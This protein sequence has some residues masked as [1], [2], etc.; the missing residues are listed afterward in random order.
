MATRRPPLTL[1]FEPRFCANHVAD[2]TAGCTFGCLYCPFADVGA[3]AAGV[4]APLGVDMTALERVP[5]PATVML[6][7]ASDPFAP[8]A[9]ARTHA[10]LAH[11]LPRGTVVA[12]LTKGTIPERTLDLLAAHAPQIEGVGVGLTSLDDARNRRLEP[13][14]PS[15]PARLDT[16]ARVA[17][18]GLAC[19]LRL[20]PIFPDL[21]DDDAAL[22]AL[23]DAA[24]DRGATGVTAT[25]LFAFG[26]SLRRLRREPL[27]AAS[28][29]CLT[30]RA[31]MEGGV[32]FSVPLGRKLATYAR[33]AGLCAARRIRF[34]TCGCKDL[35]VRDAGGFVTSCRNTE[36]AA[37]RV[38]ATRS[39]GCPAPAP[40]APGA[41]PAVPR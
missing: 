15:A 21:D 22:A 39:A 14:C 8:Q 3:R 24:A 7:P 30:E 26:R 34:S 6:S 12:L 17:R 41:P 11:L 25:Y 18:R 38:P 35:R 5:A 40:A 37:V 2:L 9:A 32:A 16:L 31:P 29:R 23:V 20:D 19:A 4:T 27:A 1:G 28:L 36:H 10:L 13:G 33:L